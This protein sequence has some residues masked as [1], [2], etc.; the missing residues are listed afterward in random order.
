MLRDSSIMLLDNIYNT[1]ITYGDRP[2]FIVQATGLNAVK[3]FGAI[4]QKKTNNKQGWLLI[5]K[6]L[7]MHTSG[8]REH[9]D[10]AT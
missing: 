4:L 8:D 3:L 5:R 6:I 7:Q 2:I 10:K 9:S 1:G